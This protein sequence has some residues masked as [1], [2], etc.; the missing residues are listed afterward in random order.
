MTSKSLISWICSD[1]Q[2]P[3]VGNEIN[4]SL[5]FKERT[6]LYLQKLDTSNH[7][8]QL[9]LALNSKFQL[10]YIPKHVAGG[11]CKVQI[12]AKQPVLLDQFVVHTDTD[13]TL[14]GQLAQLHGVSSARIK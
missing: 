5:V 3:T 4:S 7:F 8:L 14:Q 11:K 12:P 2:E 13:N 1:L 6:N 9:L 10:H